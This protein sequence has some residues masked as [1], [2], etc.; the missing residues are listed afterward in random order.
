MKKTISAI[1]SV[2][3]LLSL[4][5]CGDKSTADTLHTNGVTDE[6]NITDG[7]YTPSDDTPAVFDTVNVD[8]IISEYLTQAESENTAPEVKEDGVRLLGTAVEYD[9][10]GITVDGTAVTVNKAG[11]YSFSGTLN[12]GQIIVD[13]PKTDKVTLVFRGVDIHCSS[14]APVYVKTCDG[15][16]LTLEE[17]TVN[18]LSDGEAYVYETEGENEP[19]AA[20]FSDD[21]MKI[22]GK[23]SLVVQASFN[24]G[25]TSKNDL[26]IEDATVTVKAKH[27]GI[28]GKDCVYIKSGVVNVSSGGDGIK[29]NNTEEADRGYITV[30]G[31][32]INISAGEDGIQAETTLGINGGEFRI[33]TGE[34]S[35]NSWSGN[36]YGGASE[37]SAKAL[38]A[39][40]GVTVGGG[41]ISIDSSDDA[42]HSNGSVTVSGGSIEA[43]SGDD[44]IHADDTLNISGGNITLKKSYEGLEAVNI[45]ISGGNTHVKASDDGI[46]GA[47]GNDG[48]ATGGRPGA[49]GGMHEAS[50]AKVTVSGGYLYINADGDGLDSNGSFTMTDGTVIVDG[51]TNNGNGP[52]DYASSF[53]VSGGTLIAAGSSGMAQNVSGDSTQCTVLVYVSGQGGTLFNISADGES[54]ITYKPA[55]NYSCV[56]VSTSKL[57]TGTEYTVSTG[58]ECLGEEKD[59]LYTN[60]K[61]TGGNTD[62]TYTQSSVVS[63]AGSGG[64]MGGGGMGGGMRPGGGG[65]P[66]RW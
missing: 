62:V 31:G 48:S 10:D 13:V 65:R 44:G 52:L 58:G 29:S 8:D 20:L 21:D 23:G 66:S 60:G 14:S 64:G 42:V 57:K 35:G 39:S 22:N 15:V 3:T 47:G 18:K 55:K 17:G 5:A 36:P 32:Q 9:G 46:N 25:I 6:M 33:K 7:V 27:D 50:N 54:V 19:N 61:Y 43:S 30:D 4:C 2:F 45:N 38:K 26:K 11:T 1:L 51:P 34:G 24:N 59:G 63:S 56:L 28:R 41:K 37:A 16:T 49:W 12:D 53:T 40:V